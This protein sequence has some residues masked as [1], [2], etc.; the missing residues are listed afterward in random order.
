MPRIVGS[1]TGRRLFSEMLEARHPAQELL[2]AE[3][4]TAADL[5]KGNAPGSREFANQSLTDIE[6]RC[7]FFDLG[8][9]L[10]TL[11]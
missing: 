6:K 2:F 3:H 1:V 7:C 11:S 5:V 9:P 4:H 8:E 10:A